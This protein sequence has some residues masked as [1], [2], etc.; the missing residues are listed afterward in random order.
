MDFNDIALVKMGDLSVILFRVCRIVPRAAIAAAHVDTAGGQV[1]RY[2]P[3]PHIVEVAA[4]HLVVDQ[5]HHRELPERAAGGEY[6]VNIGDQRD[7]GFAREVVDRVAREHGASRAVWHAVEK[8]GEV[9]RSNVRPT[10]PKCGVFASE[11][12]GRLGDVDA[13]IGFPVR[14]AEGVDRKPGVAAAKVDDPQRRGL[15]A[16]LDKLP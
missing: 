4:V 16:R 1:E 10:L 6:A 9:A 12:R 14:I 3:E 13:M 8:V 15:F 5:R 2:E 11:L 7:L